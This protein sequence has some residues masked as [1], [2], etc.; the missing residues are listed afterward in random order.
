MADRVN[1][2]IV[3]AEELEELFDEQDRLVEAR[4][5]EVGAGFHHIASKYRGDFQRSFAV[6]TRMELLIEIIKSDYELKVTF[7]EFSDGKRIFD[8]ALITAAASHPVIEKDGKLTFDRESF[9]GRVMEIQNK[10][11]NNKF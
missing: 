5:A 3:T 8:T 11:R 1:S 6:T 9:F 2:V 7:P 4:Q 10:R